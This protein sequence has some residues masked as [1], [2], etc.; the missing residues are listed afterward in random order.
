MQLI[1]TGSLKSIDLKGVVLCR[2]SIVFL[3]QKQRF[4]ITKAMLLKEKINI[5]ALN[6][7]WVLM[8]EAIENTTQTNGKGSSPLSCK[9]TLHLLNQPTLH[10]FQLSKQSISIKRIQKRAS[11]HLCFVMRR[12]S[13]SI[14]YTIVLSNTFLWVDF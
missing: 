9:L 10:L 5:V 14:F 13:R 2:K 7:L 11:L 6:L 1:K 12:D 4:Y 3:S 8:T